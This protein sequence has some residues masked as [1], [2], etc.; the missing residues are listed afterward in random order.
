MVTK[1]KSSLKNI[2]TKVFS[3][4]INKDNNKNNY[5]LD[6]LDLDLDEEDIKDFYKFAPNLVIYKGEKYAPVKMNFDNDYDLKNNAQNFKKIIKKS[7]LKE[8]FENY[9]SIYINKIKDVEFNNKQ[10]TVYQYW[11]YW[12]YNI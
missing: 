10:Y 7:N 5:N 12:S 6:K 9:A 1:L 11:F 3:L 4:K 2:F 8:V